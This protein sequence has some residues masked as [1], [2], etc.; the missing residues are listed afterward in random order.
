MAPDAFVA[1]GIAEAPMMRTAVTACRLAIV[2]FIIPFMFVYN[3]ALLLIGSPVQIIQV[4]V[5]SFLGV[6]AIACAVQNYLGGKLPVLLRLALLVIGLLLIDPGW[7]S[8]LIGIPVLALIF[9]VR[10]PNTLRRFTIGLFSSKPA[11]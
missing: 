10:I 1:A 8:D 3:N 6:L 11:A 7:K 5:T 9:A 2:I 4:C